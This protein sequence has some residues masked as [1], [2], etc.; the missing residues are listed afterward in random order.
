M[1]LSKRS[2]VLH[3]ENVGLKSP[4]YQLT[5]LS[6]SAEDHLFGKCSLATVTELCKLRAHLQTTIQE[7]VRELTVLYK[8]KDTKDNTVYA[9]YNKCYRD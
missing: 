3:T 7:G 4:V 9:I 1:N 6:N 8:D 5:L 2:P